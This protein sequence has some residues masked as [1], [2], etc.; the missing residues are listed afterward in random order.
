[1]HSDR[2][3]RFLCDPNLGRLAKWLR[4]LGFDAEFMRRWDPKQVEQAVLEGRVVLTRKSCA[5]GRTGLIFIPHDHLPDQMRQVGTYLGIEK[6]ACPFSRCVVCNEPLAG[7][8]REEVKDLVPE[9]VYATQ[10]TFSTC[11][12]CRR[13][14]W[15]G[16][17]FERAHDLMGRLLEK[18]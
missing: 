13:I 3:I 15:K 7:I 14:Y 10:E 12:S 11:P 17:H 16:T 8:S 4:V 1:M 18:G 2:T 6:H 9:Y 5:R